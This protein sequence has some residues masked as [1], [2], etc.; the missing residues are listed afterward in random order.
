MS[1]TTRAVLAAASAVAVAALVDPSA[2]APVILDD[3]FGFADPE[4]LAALN[5]VLGTIGESAQVI[6]LT[7]Q[8]ERFASVGGAT[9]VSLG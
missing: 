7:C 6:L 1:R 2:G 3:A 8:P 5:V 4:R 9:T